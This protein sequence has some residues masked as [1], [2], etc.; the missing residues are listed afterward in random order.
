LHDLVRGGVLIESLPEAPSPVSQSRAILRDLLIVAAVGAAVW[1]AHRLGR[2]VLVLVL[3]M[4]FA[5]V[6]AP[7]VELLEHP[8]WFRGHS[9]RLPRGLA[10][11][12][13]YVVLAGALTGGAALLWPSA[14]EQI[15]EAILSAPKY[16][17]SFRSWEG[18]WSRYY[19]R[20]RIPLELRHSIDQSV[21]GA[22]DATGAFARGALLALLG[23]LSD[24]PWLALVP[25]LAFL[26]LKDAGTI[27]RTL[28]KALPHR[29][30]L[31]AH[32]LVE[33]LNATLS[34]FVR[35]QLIAC[36][37][38]GTLSGIGFELLG[39]P[40]AVLLGVVAAV[41]EVVPLVGP[42]V[43]AIVAVVVAALHDPVLAVW[44]A[45]FLTALRIVQTT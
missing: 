9:R 36:V 5:Y 23:A 40:Y 4:F 14:S 2:I 35:A 3:A 42:L 24:V 7:I 18:G 8:I 12:V 16:T 39:N 1:T 31:R 17:Q 43:V 25:V 33:A 34:A 13:V 22:G 29:L 45:V 15:D 6:I 20:L 11:A 38:V 10:I 30:Q 37:L 19:E 27:R 26:M 32:R 21:I 44:T 28:L 41:L